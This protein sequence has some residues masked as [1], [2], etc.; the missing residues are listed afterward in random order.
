MQHSPRKLKET[1][2]DLPG[3]PLDIFL[4][5][6][7]YLSPTE[8]VLYRRV[9]R[10]WNAA[11]T[12]HEASRHLMRQNFPRVREMRTVVGA[13]DR[14]TYT[15]IFSKVARRYAYLRSARPREV[16]RLEIHSDPNGCTVFRGFEPWR[17]WLRWNGN[18]AVFQHG[19][20]SW[21]LD[22]GL[23]VY[24]EEES[25]HYVAYDLETGRRFPV[26]FE[27]AGK[28]VRRIRLA[29]RT[30][31]IEWCEREPYDGRLLHD[32]VVIHRHFATAF[33][34]RRPT[35]S[36]LADASGPCSWEIRFRCE[37]HIPSLPLDSEGRAFSAH[38]ATHY[39][40]YFW[41]HAGPNANLRQPLERLAVWE[42][43]DVQPYRPS[44]DPEC[45]REP[46]TTQPRARV[47][48]VFNLDFLGIRQG[49][50]PLLREILIDEANVYVHE[51]DHRWLVGPH[52]SASPPRHH[53]VR[54]IGIPF[55]GVFP[56]WVDECCIDDDIHLNFCPRAGSAARLGDS[57]GCDA[58]WPGRAPCW[59][60]QDF[61][62]LTVS[63]VVDATAGVRFAARQW[64]RM[65]AFS[66]F[67]LPRTELGDV[68]DT[69]EARFAD[70][71][72]KRLLGKGNIAGDERWLVGEDQ[73]YN[74]TILRF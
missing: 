53:Y 72:W 42:I 39:A 49:S 52:S 58:A 15:H 46:D 66:S 56:R 71:V 8:C 3:L 2:F 13:P 18:E 6:V 23:L 40:G 31:V 35:E 25:G 24:M 55:S 29:E 16:E 51:E 41:E 47:I 44:E 14:S 45:V 57:N 64:F 73:F 61:P 62:F 30:L 27:G 67:V 11:L 7:S 4:L 69:N 19:D 74:I 10:S 26:P 21:S 12:N 32:E 5:I 70:N 9:S 43:K 33:D 54:S 50:R 37:W 17:R 60:H 36:G 59:R 28:I 68:D 63:E 65:E 48:Q 38:T 1:M 34:V 20:P 22:D